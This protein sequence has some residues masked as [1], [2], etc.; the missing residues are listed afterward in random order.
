L[1]SQEKLLLLDTVCKLHSR[2]ALVSRWG[3]PGAPSTPTTHGAV[4]LPAL[5]ASSKKQ[6]ICMAQLPAAPH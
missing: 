1:G 5:D 3:T 4:T 2:S 6:H